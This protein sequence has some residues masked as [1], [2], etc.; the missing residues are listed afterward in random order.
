MKLTT[1]ALCVVILTA[2]THA[3]I[4]EDRNHDQRASRLLET[5]TAT[6]FQSVV[7][8][9]F[10]EDRPPQWSA[11]L[12]VTLTRRA[13]ESELKELAALFRPTFGPSRYVFIFYIL[14]GMGIGNGAWATTHYAPSLSVEIVGLTDDQESKL[15][16]LPQPADAKLV[17]VWYTSMPTLINGRLTIY[18]LGGKVHYEWLY[19]DGSASRKPLRAKKLGNKTRYDEG[20]EFGEHYVVES[21]GTLRIGDKA[22]GLFATV[23]RTQEA[24]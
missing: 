6:K 8:S 19:L 10:V 22:N 2:W 1:V 9:I 12:W 3:G 11:V 14:P 24:K 16:A 21:D 18:T 4:A 13:T 20:N 17:G 15:R 23:A 7:K 5:Q